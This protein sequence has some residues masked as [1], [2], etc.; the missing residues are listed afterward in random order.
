M[1]FAVLTGDQFKALVKAEGYTIN[2]F[3]ESVV[4]D[5]LDHYGGNER[6]AL[7]NAK[8]WFSKKQADLLFQ[9][10]G[11]WRDSIS[12]VLGYDPFEVLTPQQLAFRLRSLEGQHDVVRGI[13]R[14]VLAALAEHDI[15][16]QLDP[17]DAESLATPLHGPRPS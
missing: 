15:Q 1:T 13:L 4:A 14:R 5:Y 6:S 3:E 12:R 8:R 9:P 10:Q 17:E 2:G 7:R 11:P 16:V